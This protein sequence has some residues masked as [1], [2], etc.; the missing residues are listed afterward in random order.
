MIIEFELRPPLPAQRVPGEAWEA[1]TG[2]PL[3]SQVVEE[4]DP[5]DTDVLHRLLDALR[6][7][8]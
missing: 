5:L 8:S 3:S 6:E 7:W 4:R 1:L 2:E